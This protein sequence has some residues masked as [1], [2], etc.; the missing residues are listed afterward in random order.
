MK[1]LNS[2]LEM[3]KKYWYLF[4]ILLLTGLV[5]VVGFVENSKMAGLVNVVKDIIENYKKQVKTVDKLASKKSSKDK[6]VVQTYEERAKQIQEKRDSDLAK[7]NAKKLEVVE[8]LKDKST[9]ELAKK[10]KEEFKL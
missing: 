9:D 2:A 5:L 8:E 1:F 3:I 4:L 6:K 10:L 7:V